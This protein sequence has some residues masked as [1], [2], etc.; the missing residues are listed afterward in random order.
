MASKPYQPFRKLYFAVLLFVIIVFTGTAGYMFI[1][2]YTLLE[3]LYMTVI[4]LSTVGY[5]EVKP[6]SDYGR[7]FTIA[8]ILFNLGAFAYLVA[9]ISSYFL[10]GEFSKEYKLY[11]M[12]RKIA[13]LE[14]H[15]IIC[16]FG[17]NGREAA[18]IFSES[19]KEFVVIESANA[20]REELAFEVPFYLN[21]D[22]TRD[23]TLK[24][25]GISK[26]SA[27]ISTLP[28][29]ADNVFVVLTARELNPKLKIVSRASTDSSVR[30]L[31]TAGADNVIMPDK[32]GGVHMASVVI[33]PD[34][35]EFVDILSTQNNDEL[36]IREIECRKPLW[37]DELDGWKKTGATIL[38]IKSETGEYKL[39]PPPRT[40]ITTGYRLIAM[41]SA[42]QLSKLQ[43]L[44][45]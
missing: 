16:G 28:E 20:R 42:D 11:N 31:K 14:G 1:E 40:T 33:S 19:G 32:I 2:H 30:K 10:D 13:D 36:S 34:I 37:L 24:E 17:R 21:E 43:L 15:I 45:Q 22:A 25:A 5:A 3:A 26:A 8:L 18:R 35:E 12:K 39:N 27:V 41:G 9:M 38:G 7:I 4:T 29:D 6:L 44:V 23:E